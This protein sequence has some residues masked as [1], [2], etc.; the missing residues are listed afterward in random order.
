MRVPRAG[1]SAEP[2]TRRAFLSEVSVAVGASFALSR[3]WVGP[4]HALALRIAVVGTVTANTVS[5]GRLGVRQGVNEA[6][7]A[8]RLFGGSIELIELASASDARSHRVTAL[9]GGRD[10]SECAALARVASDAGALYMNAWSADDALRDASHAATFHVAPSEAMRRDALSQT[11]APADAWVAAWDASL[12]RFGADT[13]NQRFAAAWKRPM[14]ADDWT[15][16]FAVKALWESSLRTRSAEP[17][18]IGA[19]LSA[20]TTQFDG[21]K[22]RGL[23]FGASDH[24]LRQPLYV[25]RRLPDGKVSLVDEVV[26]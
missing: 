13:L 9:V 1:F 11:K 17:K 10:A 2:M 15:G 6:A 18:V 5:D 20:A 7:H 4:R 25:L 21:H 22:G 12:T 26:V 3:R 8:A 23:R 19:Y 14:T 16:W 24:Q